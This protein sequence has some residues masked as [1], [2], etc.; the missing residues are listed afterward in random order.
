MD[1]GPVLPVTR[2][3]VSPLVLF[4]AGVLVLLFGLHAV[5]SGRIYSGDTVSYTHL[6]LPTN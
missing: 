6:T 2:P 4:L 3:R 1:D 5:G